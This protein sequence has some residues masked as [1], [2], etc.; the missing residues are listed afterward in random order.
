MEYRYSHLVEPSSDEAAALENLAG[1]LLPIRV[2]RDAKLADRAAF[3]AR[4]DWK[5]LLGFPLS[6][7]EG[8]G[9]GTVGPRYNFLSVLVPEMLPDRLELCAYVLEMLFFMDDAMDSGGAKTESGMAASVTAFVAE[10]LSAWEIVTRG[11][12]EV[13]V[14]SSS[15]LSSSP[16]KKLLVGLLKATFAIDRKAGEDGHRW[17]E[18][19]ATLALSGQGFGNGFESVRNF[20]D[21]LDYRLVDAA[22]Q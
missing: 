9:C 11:S 12:K 2:H 13:D 6:T 15:C 14:S 16:L 17:F 3:R 21:Y 5:R 19:W 1:G 20:D 8:E 7:P 4:K 18:K 10:Y 22:F